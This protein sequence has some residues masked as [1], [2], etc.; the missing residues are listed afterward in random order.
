MSVWDNGQSMSIEVHR[1]PTKKHKKCDAAKS[2]HQVCFPMHVTVPGSYRSL[3]ISRLK[4]KPNTELRRSDCIGY[5]RPL[6]HFS[7]KSIS[8]FYYCEGIDQGP[9]SKSTFSTQLVD[10]LPRT[11]NITVLLQSLKRHEPDPQSI[12]SF[13]G[14]VMNDCF[15]STSKTVQPY[16]NFFLLCETFLNKKSRW[17]NC[18]VNPRIILQSIH[19]FCSENL[20]RYAVHNFSA[21]LALSIKVARSNPIHLAKFVFKLGAHLHNADYM[22]E[23][24]LLYEEFLNQLASIFS[25]TS[26]YFKQKET[27]PQQQET[28]FVRRVYKES[29]N[30]FLGVY[31]KMAIILNKLGK[32]HLIIND[33]GTAVDYFNAGI[34]VDE[35]LFQ[36]CSENI[37]VAFMNIAL[38][39]RRRGDYSMALTEYINIYFLQLQAHGSH[40]LQVATSLSM[41]ALMQ[42]RLKEYSSAYE[43]YSE[44]L[45]IQRDVLGEENIGVASTINSLG[46]C[47]FYLKFFDHAKSFFVQSLRIRQKLLGC[48]NKD[49]AIIW[50]NVGTICVETGEDIDAIRCYKESL[51]IEQLFIEDGKIEGALLTIQN[52]G[53]IFQQNGEID[54]ACFYFR[55]ALELLRQ[56]NGK[57]SQSVGRL[58]NLLGNI[59]LQKAEVNEMMEC[60]TQCARIHQ[61]ENS[62]SASMV[63]SGYTFY[64][65]SK[66]HPQCANLA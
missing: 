45:A 38:I 16:Y 8:P 9:L 58:Y 48:D 54:Q 32:L 29:R 12:F 2:I 28:K 47:C 60:Y 51:R 7:N 14:H 65:L 6:I 46:L 23:S 31:P 56:T 26:N 66:L 18:Q 61:E 19:N 1:R 35:A 3:T 59:H 33:V 63:I 41:I 64:S 4:R 22:Q 42:Y 30:D 21:E 57:N 11:Q 34:K 27:I 62:K 49:L 39:H 5:K 50:Y 55:N 20:I 15:S 13:S 53:Y 25:T 10:D 44:S 40:S 43:L 52:L 24:M 36:V 37:V 17:R